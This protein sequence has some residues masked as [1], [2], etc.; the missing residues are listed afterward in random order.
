MKTF[1]VVTHFNFLF[2]HAHR[3]IGASGTR[4]AL[5]LELQP[6]TPWFET[7]RDTFL[8]VQ[9]PSDHEFTKHYIACIVV[10]WF[11]NILFLVASVGTL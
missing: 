9:Y 4:E 7:W 11:F 10:S 5:D 3:T 1:C 6:T 2:F 8:H